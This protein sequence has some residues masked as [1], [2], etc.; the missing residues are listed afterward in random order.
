MCVDHNRI[1]PLV[2]FLESKN[3]YNINEENYR[4]ETI[5]HLAAYKGYVDIVSYLLTVGADMEAKNNE[6]ATP[7]ILATS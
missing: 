7:L 4:Q 2:Y 6:G 1:K 5:L 3:N